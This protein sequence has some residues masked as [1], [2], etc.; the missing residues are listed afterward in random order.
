MR[1]SASQLYLVLSSVVCPSEKES[2]HKGSAG[3]K[4]SCIDL[5]GADVA[6]RAYRDKGVRADLVEWPPHAHRHPERD[7]SDRRRLGRVQ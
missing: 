5:G 4:S 3:P 1:V 7:W 6:S 2:D